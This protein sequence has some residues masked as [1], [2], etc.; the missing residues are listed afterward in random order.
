MTSSIE[1][2]SL[3]QRESSAPLRYKFKEG[4][5]TK[6]KLHQ[7][8]DTEMEVPGQPGPLGQSMEQTTFITNSTNSVN[9]NGSGIQT[10]VITRMLLKISGT[11][12]GMP[13]VDF[14]SDVKKEASNSAT[15]NLTDSL[16]PMIGAEFKQT[17]QP[18]G[19]VTDIVIPD[20]VAAAMKK[21][22]AAGVMGEMATPEGIKKMTT[23]GAVVFPEK[24]PVIGDEWSENIDVKLPFGKMITKRILTYVG[25]TENNMDRL[26]LATEVS[27]EATKGTGV[28]LTITNNESSGEILFDSQKGI[29][30][31][32]HLHQVTKM[33]IEAQGQTI[34]QTITTD[35]DMDLDE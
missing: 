32:S 9:S 7:T 13:N 14:D 22:A 30:S 31:K 12:P 20:Q 16:K 33:T 2:V 19:E 26:K 15:K 4:Q 24:L 23:Q 5:V 29:V 28:E 10:Q 17:I 3:A 27:F 21:N 18:T 8:V 1:S 25:K 6:Y 34:D 35:V 11:L